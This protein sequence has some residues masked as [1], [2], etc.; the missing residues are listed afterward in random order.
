[1][2][3]SLEELLEVKATHGTEAQLIA[4]G[5][6][7]GVRMRRGGLR[8]A[9]LVSTACLATGGSDL[10]FGACTTH[11][12]IE[13]MRG[14]PQLRG[15]AD[16]C[17]TIGSVQTRN[18]GTLAGNIANASPAADAVTAL[19][20]LG[21]GVRLR[22]V[23]GAREVPVADFA[24]GPG[25]TV[26]EPDEVID[27][28][29]VLA[30][31]RRCGS[32]FHKLGRRRAMEISIVAVAATL[33]LDD[34]GAVSSVRLAL[35]AVGPT[36]IDVPE[37]STMLRGRPVRPEET[38]HLFDELAEAAAHAARPRTDHRAGATYRREMSRLLARRALRDAWER[39][40]EQGDGD[41]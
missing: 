32:A 13:R 12:A 39:A 22:S 30:A 17:R 34:T 8:P 40:T 9:L 10:T 26:L 41:G 14:E 6:D 38:Q 35:G 18:V 23:D 27:G 37:A 21:A 19:V 1:M 4:G 25:Q 31:T 15:L 11:R 33:Q 29:S 7:L 20:S 16:A 36:V 3:R 2:P 24:R 28:V 5:T